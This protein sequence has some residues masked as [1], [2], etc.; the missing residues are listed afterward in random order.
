MDFTEAESVLNDIFTEYDAAEHPW[1][2][3]VDDDNDNQEET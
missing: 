1:G 3:T 2:A